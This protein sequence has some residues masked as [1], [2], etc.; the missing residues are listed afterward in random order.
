MQTYFELNTEKQ[1]HR[2][3]FNKLILILGLLVLVACDN[4]E[5]WLEGDLVTAVFTPGF[6]G[7]SDG[8]WIT[9]ATN[10]TW[11]ANDKVGI[12][13]LDG[14][15]YTLSSALKKNVEYYAVS[16]STS[17][18][19]NPVAVANTIYYPVNGDKVR[20]VAYSPY[21]TSASGN[22]QVAYTFTDQADKAKKEA[23]DFIFYR[24]TTDRS[25]TSA[26]ETMT[27]KHKFSKISIFVKQGTNGPSCSGLTMTLTK[28]P[29]SATVNLATLASSET[30]ENAVAG[31]GISTSSTTISAYTSASA[32]ASAS[33]EAIVAPHTG[34]GNF[35]SRTF[36][37]GTTGYTYSLPNDVTFEAG[38]VYNYDMVLTST[39]IVLN[40]VTISDWDNKTIEI[41][42]PA[43]C[44]M[45][46]PGGYS[47]MIP[48]SRANEYAQQLGESETFTTMMYW[49][50]AGDCIKAPVTAGTGYKGY[51]QVTS[52]TTEGNAVVALRN[53]SS[54]VLWSW[55]IWVTDYD[56]EE[57]EAGTYTN[58]YT[59][60]STNY[61]FTFMDRHLGAKSGDPEDGIGTYGLHYQWGRK[62]PFPSAGTTAGSEPTI[63]TS[64]ATLEKGGVTYAMST[65]ALSSTYFNTATLVATQKTIAWTIA[66]PQTFIGVTGYWFTDATITDDLWGNSGGKTIFDPC[67]KGWRVPKNVAISHYTSPWYGF[68]LDNTD[69][70]TYPNIMTWGAGAAYPLTGCR[71]NANGA[72]LSVGSG[73]YVWT[74]SYYTNSK[75]NAACMKYNVNAVS[76]LAT[77]DRADGFSVRCAKE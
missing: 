38:K 42:E 66:N 50:D 77:D 13:M 44:Y 32:A 33:I 39:G 59:Y 61:S 74:A 22:N 51:I 52:G 26:T 28:M 71:Q 5:Q 21:N 12:Y 63:Y 31:L 49:Q 24:G 54:K 46:K 25:K 48:V 47:I 36:T 19:L 73:G 43:N 17:T 10:N 27:F 37:F 23:K 7:D 41:G 58:D 2:T 35:T 57:D 53:S 1:R 18:V 68:A 64:S 45:L 67:P 6:A 20:F 8:E 15:D 56:P 34:A 75:T 30:N 14:S 60:N 11:T 76:P 69:K 9:R 70:T 3:F 62:D 40:G 29:L 72:L 65:S 55:H 4:E 16:G